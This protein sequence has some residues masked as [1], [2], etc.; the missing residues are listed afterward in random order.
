VVRCSLAAVLFGLS[1]PAASRLVDDLGAFGLAGLLYLG[2][3][4]ATLLPTLRQPPQRRSLLVAAK[5]LAIAVVVGGAIGPLLLAAGL[6]RTTAA[7]ASLL[8][9][10]ELVFT[11]V[12]AGLIF[13]EHIGG[14]LAAGTGLVVTAGLLLA[15]SGAPEVRWGAVLVAGACLC[16]AVDN[17]VTAALDELSPAHI[18]FVKGLVAGS[19]NFAIGIALNGVPP[20]DASLWAVAVG[21]VGYGMSITLWVAGARDLGA[22]RGQLVFATAPFIG[23]VAAWVVLGEAATSREIVAA[24]IAGCGVMFVMNSG[25][26]HQHSHPAAQHDHEHVHDDGHHDHQHDDG[27]RGRHQHPHTHVAQVHTHAHV[28][29]VHHRHGHE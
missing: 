20:L 3:A 23:A 1:A 28:P 27:F 2:A 9:N 26:E 14:R 17:S 10:L 7:T 16:W 18:T 22:A 29:D 6:L 4:L 21:V 25:H 24:G 5:P 11:T 13:K 12:I 19:V 8:L 15:W